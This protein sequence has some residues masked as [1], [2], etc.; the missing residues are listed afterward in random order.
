MKKLKK[1]E[2]YN[3]V[4]SNLTAKKKRS[5]WKNNKDFFICHDK[6]EY[7]KNGVTLQKLS[8]MMRKDVGNWIYGE[9]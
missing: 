7:G 6:K 2:I 8:L 9:S 4:K 1:H 3:Q 5:G